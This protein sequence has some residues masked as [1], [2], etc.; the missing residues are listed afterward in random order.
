[1]KGWEE[2]SGRRASN[3]AGLGGTAPSEAAAPQARLQE[4]SHPRARTGR[5]QVCCARG[6][7]PLHKDLLTRG[8]AALLFH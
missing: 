6:P 1:M 8:S 4:E 2:R 7:C 3:S 5:T